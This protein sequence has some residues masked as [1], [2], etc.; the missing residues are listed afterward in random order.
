MAVR[1][2][3]GS[4]RSRSSDAR[5]SACRYQVIAALV[6]HRSCPGPCQRHVS[7]LLGAFGMG[8]TSVNA[9]ARLATWTRSV[10][11]LGFAQGYRT[12]GLQVARY[13]T[14]SAVQGRGICGV[15]PIRS[16]C[17]SVR[18]VTRSLTASWLVR[19]GVLFDTRLAQPYSSSCARSTLQQA[20]MPS[21]QYASTSKRS[22][23]TSLL[24]LCKFC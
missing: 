12:R 10:G 5:Q 24:T 13:R 7:V 6:V 19:I 18:S 9:L 3:P 17:R 2:A 20:R 15:S 8:D 22:S 16:S 21:S 1:C 11:L 14:C 4:A 23:R